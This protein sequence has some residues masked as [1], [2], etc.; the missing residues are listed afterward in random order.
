[1]A[2]TNIDLELST[3]W[4]AKT[5]P[6][7]PTLRMRELGD[8]NANWT[9]HYDQTLEGGED[10][11]FIGALQWLEDMSITK[12]KVNWNSLNPGRTVKAEQKIIPAPDPLTDEQ[13]E[14]AKEWYGQHIVKWCK[15]KVG[16]RVGDGECWSLADEA[17]KSVAPQMLRQGLEPP[18]NS[19]GKVHGQCIL[20]YSP[21]DQVPT[22][23]L[24]EMAKV[25]VGDI[26]QMEDGHFKSVRHHSVFNLRSEANVRL[27]HHT[28]VIVG[29]QGDRMQV[30]EQNTAVDGMVSEGHFKLSDMQTGTIRFFRPV[31]QT[32][33][34]NIKGACK[35][36]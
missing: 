25:K 21:A 5:P 10:W 14:V 13:L 4:F 20:T 36:W 24:L 6:A 33:C 32:W 17:L 26:M 11:E 15:S 34:P 12:I 28:A 31:G 22:E 16:T 27:K 9:W 8:I 1:M 35:E 23:G 19:Q 2:P 3:L 18:M 7:F 30:I 29:V